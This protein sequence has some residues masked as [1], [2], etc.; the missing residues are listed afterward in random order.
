MKTSKFRRSLTLLLICAFCA[1]LLGAPAGADAQ[2]LHRIGILDFFPLPNPR[3]DAFRQ[4]LRDLGYVEGRDVAIVT[5]SAERVR[6]RLPRLASEMVAAKVDVIVVTSG[7]SALAVKDATSAIPVVMTA[8]SDAVAMGIV[9]SLAR[10]GGNVTGLTIISPDLA[11]KR[12]ELLLAALPG[13]KK[14]AVL[15]CPVA[16][17]NHEELRR[18]SAAAAQLGIHAESVEYHQGTTSWSSVMHAFRRARPHAL[19]LLD[20]TYLP[21][22]E[23]VEFAIQ[24]RLPTMTP[25]IGLGQQGALMAYGPDTV[26]MARRA[27]TYVDK[28][29]KGMNP[30][31]LPV[32]QPTQFELVVNRKTARAIG[33][34]LPQSILLRASSVID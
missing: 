1:A 20:C 32:E 33:L 9:T 6:D 21:F 13:I 34:A 3:D 2:K 27:A 28:I 11:A 15:W 8:S 26:P 17:V 5:R 29:I 19:F 18:T 7:T 12:L 30:A 23:I 16:P 25:Y 14:I 10:P 4:A 24:Q 22:Q 31:D